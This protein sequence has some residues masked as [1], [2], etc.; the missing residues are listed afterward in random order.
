MI[1]YLIKMIKSGPEVQIKTL[2][3]L[4]HDSLYCMLSVWSLSPLADRK[5]IL[6]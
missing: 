4:G 1:I 5:L 6:S 2:N 3:P